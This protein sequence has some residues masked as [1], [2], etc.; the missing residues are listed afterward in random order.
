VGERTGVVFEGRF[1][2]GPDGKPN[3]ETRAEPSS[4]RGTPESPRRCEFA[5]TRGSDRHAKGAAR[6]IFGYLG[7]VRFRGSSAGL[8]YSTAVGPSPSI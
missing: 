7:G 3:G 6:G 8:R 2:I 5:Y 1:A 4:V